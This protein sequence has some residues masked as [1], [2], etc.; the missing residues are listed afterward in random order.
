MV[1]ESSHTKDSVKTDTMAAP[2]KPKWG[3][4]HI[5]PTLTIA[6]IVV[7][8]HKFFYSYHAGWEFESHDIGPSMKSTYGRSWWHSEHLGNPSLRRIE[9]GCIIDDRHTRNDWE[10]DQIIDKGHLVHLIDQ[11]CGLLKPRSFRHARSMTLPKD[12]WGQQNINQFQG[13]TVV[14]PH[15]LCEAG[16]PLVLSR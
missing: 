14:D 11:P 9:Q 7:D 3:R 6:G 13:A 16:A 15:I 1:V 12:V 4:R 5:Q 2:I 8:Q 10:N